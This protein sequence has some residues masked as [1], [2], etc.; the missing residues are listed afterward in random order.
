MVLENC[1]ITNTEDLH[2]ETS[3]RELAIMSGKFG[4]LKHLLLYYNPCE[5]NTDINHC[6]K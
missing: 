6:I 1:S 5:S 2:M 4:V 3:L